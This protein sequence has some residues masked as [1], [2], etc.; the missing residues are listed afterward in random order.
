MSKS[1][2]KLYHKNVMADVI[3]D[4]HGITQLQFEDLGDRISP[5][6]LQL[7]KQRKAGKTPYRDLPYAAEIA[8]RVR[9]VVA[10]VRDDCEILVV[11]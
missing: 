2:I 3:G 7:N 8:E 9:E 4:D 5:L 1:E 6:I 11:L 10:E